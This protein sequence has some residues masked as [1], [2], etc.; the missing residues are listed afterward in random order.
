MRGRSCR[1]AGVRQSSA[2]DPSGQGLI[3]TIFRQAING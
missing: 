3:Q 2:R 1:I